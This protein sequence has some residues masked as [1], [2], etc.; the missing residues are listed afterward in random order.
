MPGPNWEPPDE[1]RVDPSAV[2]DIEHELGFHASEIVS[3]RA[4][5]CDDEFPILDP[6]QRESLE[7]S[8][9]ADRRW[10]LETLHDLFDD[11]KDPEAYH[12]ESVQTY[13]GLAGQ[14]LLIPTG[15]RG[16][17]TRP[18]DLDEEELGVYRGFY[19]ASQCFLECAYGP[20]CFVYRG[21]RE[22]SIA[23]LFAQALDYPESDRYYFKTSTISNHSGLEAIGFTHSNG[24]VVQ[25]DAPREYVAAA[26]DQLF[27]TPAPEDEYHVVG[28]MLYVG[29]NGVIHEGRE[30]GDRRKLRTTIE[31]LEDPSDMANDEHLDVVDLVMMMYDEE[32]GVKTPEGARRLLQW[33]EA[34]Q[35]TE[36]LTARKRR[37]VHAA[38][39][40]L[41]EVD[42]DAR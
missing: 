11:W 32:I 10:A 35:S 42:V 17:P 15:V 16:D 13:E 3:M 19:L 26:V 23:S 39:L 7:T 12:E 24:I 25:W 20:S 2:S 38:V 4:V 21:I 30:T 41:S 31:R 27:D 29:Q 9:S 22:K 33:N 37:L 36:V 14:A 40:F 6:D 1:L 8:L 18:L 5:D 34:F 28:G